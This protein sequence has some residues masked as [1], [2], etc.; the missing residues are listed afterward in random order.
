M[1]I[2]KNASRQCV[3]DEEIQIEPLN[4]TSQNL[5][6]NIVKQTKFR[7]CKNGTI[8]DSNTKTDCLKSFDGKIS[9]KINGWL[10][11]KI[12]LGEGGH[13]DNVYDEVY[14]LCEWIIKYNSLKHNDL[15]IILIDTNLI[16]KLDELT[17]KYTDVNNIIIGNHITI[18]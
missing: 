1:Y 15:F 13:Q 12:V 16:I 18:Q 10:F 14:N 8:I 3:N 9:G 17:K 2:A 6:I 11:A 5:G 7:P 4:L